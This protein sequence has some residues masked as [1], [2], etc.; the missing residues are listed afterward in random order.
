MSDLDRRRGERLIAEGRK[1]LDNLARRQSGTDPLG[2]KELKKRRRRAESDIREGEA[3]LNRATPYAIRAARDE[4][5][6][7]ERE[8]RRAEDVWSDVMFRN[9]LT[10]E[11]RRR[12][13]PPSLASLGLT[14][15]ESVRACRVPSAEDVFDSL[16][17]D[18]QSELSPADPEVGSADQESSAAD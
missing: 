13:W 14:D 16:L 4:V 8:Y 9:G 11:A 17:P 1:R 2:E 5:Y 15:E 12:D 3:I 6:A 10:R 18:A 7:A